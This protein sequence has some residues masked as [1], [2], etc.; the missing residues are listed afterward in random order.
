MNER[1]VEILM[2]IMSQ[3]RGG[4]KDFDNLDLLSQDL[5]NRGYSQNEISSAFS[6]LFERADHDI[7][8]ILRDGDSD[9][10]QSFRVLHELEEMIISA[11]AFGYL[12]QIK[13]LEILSDFDVELA[14]EKAMMLG[15]SRVHIEDM[16]SIVAAILTTRSSHFHGN[17]PFDNDMDAMIH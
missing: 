8:E 2:F 3:L 12:L 17:F 7:E 4:K 13:Q 11:D 9:I 10:S 1:V 15:V 14:I 16:K 6:W 5:L